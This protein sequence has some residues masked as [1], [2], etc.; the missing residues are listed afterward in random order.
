ML[1]PKW[2]SFGNAAAP[3]SSVDVDVSIEQTTLASAEPL[4]DA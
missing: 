2:R 4:L 1:S 3:K